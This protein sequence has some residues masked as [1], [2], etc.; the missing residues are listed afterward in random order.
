MAVALLLAGMEGI[1]HWRALAYAGATVADK[2]HPDRMAVDEE[3]PYSRAQEIMRSFAV[4]DVAGDGLGRAARDAACRLGDATAGQV[5][6]HFIPEDMSPEFFWKACVS[7][8]TRSSITWPD[9][10]G[11]RNA[12]AQ[13]LYYG[14]AKSDGTSLAILAS[15]LTALAPAFGSGTADGGK[16]L[17]L[18]SFNSSEIGD[19]CWTTS[20][21]LSQY[22]V[23]D[24]RATLLAKYA[25]AGI[26]SSPGMVAI[27]GTL[28]LSHP[29][30]GATMDLEATV[31][32]AKELARTGDDAVALASKNVFRKAEYVP[33]GMSWLLPVAMMRHDVFTLAELID[34]LTVPDGD[35]RD[36]AAVVI[37]RDYPDEWRRLKDA[38]PS[39]D[40]GKVA[41]SIADS[42]GVLG[43]RTDDWF[44]G[45]VAAA[46]EAI[47]QGDVNAI[48]RAYGLLAC[49]DWRAGRALLARI[50]RDADAPLISASTFRIVDQDWFVPHD[51]RVALLDISI[52]TLLGR[53]AVATKDDVAAEAMSTLFTLM[54]PGR[55]GG[56]S[57][58]DLSQAFDAG[59]Q[60]QKQVVIAL[61]YFVD[62]P[63]QGEHV[64]AKGLA[65]SDPNV[66]VV[67]ALYAPMISDGLTSYC[68]AA[69]SGNDDAAAVASLWVAWRLRYSDLL[70]DLDAYIERLVSR[71]LGG[72]VPGGIESTE[73]GY[74]KNAGMIPF[75]SV[76]A[77]AS[78]GGAERSSKMLDSV[79]PEVR[80][81]AAYCNMVA[82]EY[83][84][85]PFL[86]PLSS[87]YDT[88]CLQV[89]VERPKGVPVPSFLSRFDGP[90]GAYIPLRLPDIKPKTSPPRAQN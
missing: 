53:M 89:H 38:R 57:E 33:E 59:T 19:I 49:V 60:F 17:P 77:F 21:A 87:D 82:T 55:Q 24:V 13:M 36:Y 14:D 56:I 4:Q 41:K 11:P 31:Y 90:D 27:T 18:S 78:A 81:G 39:I 48:A 51:E 37:A 42:T 22:P 61:T 79:L 67:A 66:R 76:L 20:R 46:S 52:S 47:R 44:D 5:L 75:L 43:R 32:A 71:K 50:A 35:I 9:C 68:R 23:H 65:E 2:Q 80:L 40:L 3:R 1:G 26:Y 34:F 73:S 30:R 10:S 29:P 86:W 7:R 84:G 70:P 8:D 54:V 25:N 69:L 45:P 12:Y 58:R 74:V 72:M 15:A 6:R 62:L 64:V 85:Q 63:G 88:P 83:P 28:G 16:V